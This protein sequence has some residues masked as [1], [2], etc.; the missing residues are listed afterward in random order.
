MSC[1]VLVLKSGT[2]ITYFRFTDRV[3]PWV[4]Y[5]PVQVDLSDL[6]DSLVFFRGDP[7]GD[8]AHD[9][10]ARK[11]A[12]AGRQWSKTFWRKEDLTAYMFRSISISCFEY[13]CF[14]MIL[15]FIRCLLQIVFG[16]CTRHEP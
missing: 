11:I 15:I 16:V 1:I 14:G 12:S 9:D 5:I 4:H 7:N 2:H 8:N 6:Y 3:A 10:L 13:C